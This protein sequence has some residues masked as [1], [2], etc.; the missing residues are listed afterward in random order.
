VFRQ[1]DHGQGSRPPV[2]KFAEF[3][4]KIA[5]ADMGREGSQDGMMR[6][7]DESRAQQFRHI[8]RSVPREFDHATPGG[9]GRSRPVGCPSPREI[10]GRGSKFS[11]LSAA[12]G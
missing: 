11:T 12:A 10:P 7:R 3:S 6:H 4:P 1:R 2:S 5:H 9:G 8:W